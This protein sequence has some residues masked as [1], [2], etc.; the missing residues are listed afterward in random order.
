[1]DKVIRLNRF[2][3]IMLLLIL[4][5]VSCTP[6]YDSSVF[7]TDV[8]ESQGCELPCWHG[9][10]PGQASKEDLLHA[11]EQLPDSKVEN[12]QQREVP[13]YGTQIWW[14]DNDIGS[15]YNALFQENKLIY[16]ESQPAFDI[17]LGELVAAIG[18]PEHYIATLATGEKTILYLD[19]FYEELG[20]QV[21]LWNTS[22]GE[23]LIRELES[24]ESPIPLE[25]TIQDMRIMSP[26]TA[27][28]MINSI[29]ILQSNYSVDQ[30]RPWSDEGMYLSDCNE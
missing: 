23:T 4:V 7:L 20:I 2:R 9:L 1:M 25:T 12:F 14:E 27:E 15:T 6:D 18:S 24:C 21:F 8:L 10:I 28:S 19:L 26:Q 30:L 13:N 29:S 17:A 5:A 22:P 11:L 3:L 16:I